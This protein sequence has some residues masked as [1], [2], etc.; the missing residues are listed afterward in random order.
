VDRI[1]TLA[2][3]KPYPIQKLCVALVNRMYNEKR[4]HITVAD[5]EAIS[6][7]RGA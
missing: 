6:E 3:C 7:S 5:V 1:I 2:D 4:R